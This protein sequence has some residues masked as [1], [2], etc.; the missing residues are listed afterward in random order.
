MFHH[1]TQG[2]KAQKHSFYK[3]TET[4][5]YVRCVANHKFRRNRNSK[6]KLKVGSLK[7]ISNATIAQ[8]VKHA[9]T[10]DLIE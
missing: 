6:V 10:D 3:A 2:E 1:Q 7:T 4:V 9:M 8:P 5:K